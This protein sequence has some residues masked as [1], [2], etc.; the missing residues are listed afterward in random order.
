MSD[1][2]NGSAGAWRSSS[3]RRF[4][5]KHRVALLALLTYNAIL[6]FPLLFMGRVIS[7]NDVFFNTDPWAIYRSEPAQ[8]SQLNDPP[9]SYLTVMSLLRDD[10]SS[11]HWNPWVACGIPGFGSAAAAVLS[12]FILLPT[13]LL[14][15]SGVWSGIIFLKLNAGFV[16]AYLW[17]R[18]ERLGKGPAALGAVV[19]G[20]AGI[21]A[22]RW[23]WQMT[24]AT[25]LFPVI[26]W[27]LARAVHGKRNSVALLTLL[28]AAYGLAGFPATMADGAWCCAAYFVYSCI[29][30]KS[31][32]IRGLAEGA[33]AIALGLLI[34]APSIV[35]MVQFLH[36]SGYLEARAGASFEHFFPPSHWASFIDPERL[37]N[38]AYKNWFGDRSLGGLNNF[39]E[40]TVYLGLVCLLFVPFAIF[41]RRARGRWFWLAAGGLVLSWMFGVGP[42]VKPFASLPGFRY[43]P[44]TRTSVLLPL[45]AGFLAA[46]GLSF[47]SGVFRRGRSWRI[48]GPVVRTVSVLVA[49]A[50]AADL[51]VFAAR[52]FPYLTPEA[53]RIPETPV[54]RYLHDQPGEFRIAPMLNYLWPNSSELFRLE[55]VRSHFG[56]E[57]YYRAMLLRVDPTCWGTGS[58][59]VQFNSLHFN[60]T[61]PF[62]SLLGVRYLVEH[63]AIEIIKWSVYKA[64]VQ[65]V[66]QIGDLRIRPGQTLRRT[67][68]FVSQ[69]FWALELPL[70]IESARG[71][72]PALLIMLQ[73][74]DGKVLYRHLYAPKELEGLDRVYVAAPQGEGSAILSVSSFG[75]V[76]RFLS[77]EA[78]AGEAPIFYGRVQTP[79]ILERELPDGRLFRNLAE[80]PRFQP[81]WQTRAMSRKEFLDV[82]DVD[83]RREAILTAAAKAIDFSAV[84]PGQR[85][86]AVV[87]S[88]HGGDQVVRV[89]SSAAFF[90]A[91]SEKLTP[92][93]RIRVDGREVP[94]VEINGLFAGVSIP[95]GHHDVV[96]SRR[97]GRG[98]WIPALLALMVWVGIAAFE[99]TRRFRLAPAKQQTSS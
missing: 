95:A 57:A 24:N 34:V 94:A 58:T 66:R 92:E 53:T 77:A 25:A 93:L 9:T 1:S 84:P 86:A 26:L 3:V 60:F 87:H 21:Y 2:D 42:L 16:F 19:A 89:A 6:F 14:P 11:F 35:P 75:V 18:E 91:S 40:T 47:V 29:R 39:V 80:V 67:I 43:T 12:P 32:P 15:L 41:A 59:I 23:M 65:G 81:V 51:A 13:L 38:P 31:L 36:R 50:A 17:L 22:I 78:A 88:R 90:L 72:N 5:R 97:I 83:F 49:V 46:A 79:I 28:V 44:M 64:T 69:P 85:H 73:R 8:N 27:A 48:R 10:W 61:H 71:R 82:T 62:V 70:S 45:S 76:A 30:E 55:D 63:K 56:S 74:A 37:G 20:G 54:I 52:S 99:A 7:P 68:S 96:F 4:L 33:V 98:W